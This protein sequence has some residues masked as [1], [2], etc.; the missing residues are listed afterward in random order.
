M[1]TLK[2]SHPRKA[3]KTTARRAKP[4][5]KT[6]RSAASKSVRRTTKIARSARVGSAKKT[7]RK[8]ATKPVRV[9]TVR[10]TAASR[11]AKSAGA[12]IVAPPSANAPQWMNRLRDGT[13]VLIRPIRKTD[14]ALERAFIE[15]LSDESRRFRF[16]GYMKSPSAEMVK[17]L[18]D[19]DYRREMAFVALIHDAGEKK[20]IGVSRYSVGADGKSCECAV[21]VAD[22]WQGRGL[23]ALLM[24]HLIDVA[25]EQG[26]KQMMSIDASENTQMRDL[27]SYLGFQRKPDPG[28]PHQVIY[29]LDL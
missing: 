29:S 3:K 18:T 10:K 24:R 23:G 21:A 12:L 7:S 13:H 11:P 28:D 6:S 2:R 17:R 22:D 4:A 14:A 9:R 26:I 5:A 16:L 1:A 27:A 25:R 20:E 15:R 8:V 19:I